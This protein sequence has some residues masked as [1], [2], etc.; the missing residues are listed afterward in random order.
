MVLELLVNPKKIQGKRWEMF[1]VG[2]V[3]SAFALFLS[4]FTFRGYTSLAMITFTVIASVPFVHRIIELEEKKDLQIKKET[5]LLRE[6][7]KAI[8][9]FIYLFLGFVAAFGILYMILPSAIIQ[10]VFS[11]QIET[12]IAVNPSIPVGSFFSGVNALSVIFLNNLKILFLCIVFSFFYGAGAIFIL[13]WNAS[14]MATAIGAFIKA[15]LL[16][17]GGAIGYLEITTF[18]LLQFMV[19]GIPEI[20]AFFI[21]GLASGIISFAIVKHDLRGKNF[22]RI[23]FDAADLV[24]IAV[25]ILFCAAIV[26]VYISP[27]IA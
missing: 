3:Y 21:G 19:H 22:R 24:M 16:N 25:I 2:F 27:F 4:L 17:A 6:H 18:G 26:E 1:F 14:L 15:N 20:S 23:L 7:S 11:A 12:I 9:T 8:R 10:R 13:T 5:S